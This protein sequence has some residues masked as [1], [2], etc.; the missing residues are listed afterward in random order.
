MRRRRKSEFFA[1]D[2]DLLSQYELFDAAD[3]VSSLAKFDEL[4]R[5][6]TAAGNAASQSI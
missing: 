6:I 1:F 5:P 4:S 3:L 2:G